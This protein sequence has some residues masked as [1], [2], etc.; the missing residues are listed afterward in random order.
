MCE[1]IVLLL[2]LLLLLLC[3][4]L[5][6]HQQLRSK[7]LY[8]GCQIA[9][10]VISAFPGYIHFPKYFLENKIG[11]KTNSFKEPNGK[12]S[13]YLKIYQMVPRKCQGTYNTLCGKMTFL[14]NNC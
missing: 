4:C 6:P 12:S 3:L 9:W 10:S 11:S 1:H 8:S 14:I 13:P 2:L 7:V 5:M